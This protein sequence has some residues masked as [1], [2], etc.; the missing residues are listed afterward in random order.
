MKN[1]PSKKHNKKKMKANTKISQALVNQI[2]N[3]ILTNFRASV[4]KGT[5]TK[6]MQVAARSFC[7]GANAITEA[8]LLKPTKEEWVKVFEKIEEE[9]GE[10]D[11]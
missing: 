3:N 1:K 5:N 11:F 2:T 7:D 6:Q 4:A 9:L 10:Y 8:M